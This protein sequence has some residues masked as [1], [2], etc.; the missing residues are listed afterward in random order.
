MPRSVVSV[1]IPEYVVDHCWENLLYNKS[2]LR[3]KSQLLFAYGKHEAPC[4]KPRE[5]VS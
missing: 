5:T 4:P 3:L 2:A 1:Y